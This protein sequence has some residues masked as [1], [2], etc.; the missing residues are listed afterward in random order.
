[1]LKLGPLTVTVKP[2]HT[3]T[4]MRQLKNPGLSSI[5]H[6][7]QTKISPK[8]CSKNTWCRNE[9]GI[10]TYM[11]IEYSSCA[12]TWKYLLHFSQFKV[13]CCHY[14]HSLQFSPTISLNGLLS[15]WKCSHHK[16]QLNSS[17]IRLSTITESK[18]LDSKLEMSIFLKYALT[19]L[20]AITN[21]SLNSK[22]I[23]DRNKKFVI[24]TQM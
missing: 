9:W 7:K 17:Y 24:C 4:L 19:S 21:V 11:S 5:R 23:N 14:Y 6:G 18:N 3:L 15:I 16:G 1:M 8:N 12:K 20:I 10:S 2:R 13:L 22:I